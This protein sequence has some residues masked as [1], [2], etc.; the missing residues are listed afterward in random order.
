MPHIF[1]RTVTAS[2]TFLHNVRK[3]SWIFQL[4]FYENFEQCKGLNLCFVWIP[5]CDG[6]DQKCNVD[7]VKKE[8]LS[9]MMHMSNMKR[10]SNMIYMSN[11]M[12]MSNMMYMSNMMNMSNMMYSTCRIWCF[13]RIWCICRIDSHFEYDAHVK[14]DKTVYLPVNYIF[15][16]LHF[17]TL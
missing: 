15:H 14:Y 8:F 6:G 3:N 5:G 13:C 10:L 11:M 12:C 4:R 2:D 16:S 7:Q 17:P 1:A 9:N